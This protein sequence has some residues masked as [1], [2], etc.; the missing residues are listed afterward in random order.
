MIGD[1]IKKN[2]LTPL[3]VNTSTTTNTPS[4]DNMNFEH[5]LFHV[6]ATTTGGQT[7]SFAVQDSDDNSSFAAVAGIATVTISASQTNASRTVLVDQNRVRRYLRLR[8]IHTGSATMASAV[9]L[10]QNNSQSLGTEPDVIF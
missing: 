7:I 5:A 9:V 8:I 10:Q 3:A 2:K 4:V 1:D 6:M